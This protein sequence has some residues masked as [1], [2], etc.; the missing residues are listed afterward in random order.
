MGW[1]RATIYPL[2]TEPNASYKNRFGTRTP[3]FYFIWRSLNP[4]NSSAAENDFPKKMMLSHFFKKLLDR[5][6]TLVQEDVDGLAT[7]SS[8][9][10]HPNSALFVFKSTAC[11]HFKSF[12]QLA[13]VS[14]YKKG[15]T[16]LT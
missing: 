14:N 6:D 11:Q 12:H 16:Y 7:R 4:R 5:H 13:I 15:L 8:H 2:Q 3:D 9:R 1:D 10:Q